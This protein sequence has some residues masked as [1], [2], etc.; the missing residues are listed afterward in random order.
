MR[1]ALIAYGILNAVLYASLLPLWEGFDEPFH[2]AYVQQL[3]ARHTLPLL[4]AS[5]LS[6]EVLA[7]LAIAPASPSVKQNLPQVPT[8]EDYFRMPASERN[9]M[10]A[11]LESLP[12][13]YAPSTGLNYE[14]QQAPL[15]YLLLAPADRMWSSATLPTRIWRLRLV[16]GV[17]AS[18]ATAFFLFLLAQRLHLPRRFEGALVFTVLSSQMFYATTAH[19]SNDW[20]AVPLMVA[21][22][23]RMAAIVE[24][25]TFRNAALLAFA[26][27][28][29]VL[30][31]AY[32]LALLPVVVGI[33]LA[34]ALKKRLSWRGLAG[35]AAIALAG[36]GPWYARNVILYRNLSGMLQTNGGTDWRALATAF[37]RVPWLS[38][39]RDMLF[40]GLWTGN[41]SF[42]RFSFATLLML[43]AGYFAA[44]VA[45]AFRSAQRRP[46][47][48]ELVVLAG[49][50]AYAV[51][52]LYSA[53]IAFWYSH[54]VSDTAS[55]WFVQPLLPALS[56]VL[57]CG[58]ARAGAAGKSIAAWLACWSAYVIF[59]TYWV[60]LIPLYSGY[61]E[62]RTTLFRL[63]PWYHH[64]FA[65]L[66]GNPSA[67]AMVEPRPV[68]ALAAA[69]AVSAFALAAVLSTRLFTSTGSDTPGS[70]RR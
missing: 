54:G 28:A 45:Y 51:S 63:L 2:Y 17:F 3:S 9:L 34:L 11:R 59:A 49:C 29:G 24:S 66:L 40:A 68:F 43:A 46:P 37:T 61:S 4:G 33:V 32:L 10:R 26:L 15:A 8:Y 13:E 23:D 70:P 7:S 22:L 48:P 57:F 69:A 53:T 64:N 36:A 41:N 60:K 56:A 42:W 67:T 19:V 35:F 62:G 12:G 5:Y 1:L 50:A 21:L 30:S 39:L 6:R 52:L 58:L 20:L 44:V 31:K 16:C 14:A 65:A 47:L 27:V 25:P 18:A 38:S 55:P